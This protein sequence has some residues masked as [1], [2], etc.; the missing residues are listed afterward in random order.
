MRTLAVTRFSL[1][2]TGCGFPLVPPP[3]PRD[4][5]CWWSRPPTMATLGG[6]GKGRKTDGERGFLGRAGGRLCHRAKLRR[7]PIVGIT[8]RAWMAVDRTNRATVAVGGGCGRSHRGKGGRARRAT[9]RRDGWERRGRPTPWR[10]DKNAAT[11]SMD[12]KRQGRDQARAERV[13]GLCD[14]VR[15]RCIVFL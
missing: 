7:R 3:P 12:G 6:A 8:C 11:P 4:S 9:W 2:V 10:G 14:A 1:A 13:R 15:I 5:S